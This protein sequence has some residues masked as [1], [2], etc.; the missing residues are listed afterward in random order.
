M[1]EFLRRCPDPV[2]AFGRYPQLGESLSTFSGRYPLPLCRRVASLNKKYLDARRDEFSPIQ[3]LAHHVPE[4][5][6]ELG[7]SL[8]FSPCI[9]Y[10]FKRQ[11]H[12]DIME[13]N[14]LKTLSK[15]TRKIRAVVPDLG[16][17]RLCCLQRLYFERA[18]VLASLKRLP[19]RRVALHAGN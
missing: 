18:L 12:M 2:A 16:L 7:V 14:S 15:I 17:Q 9:Q 19:P 13:Q 1:D 10:R 6:I 4:W 5:V 3:R 8:E 11:G